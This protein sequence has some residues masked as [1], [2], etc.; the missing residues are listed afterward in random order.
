MKLLVLERCRLLSFEVAQLVVTLTVQLEQY[1][2]EMEWTCRCLWY[3]MV[4][5]VEVVVV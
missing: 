1:V 5:V 2:V 4:V 3:W